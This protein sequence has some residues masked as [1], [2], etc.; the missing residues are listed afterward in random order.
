MHPQPTQHLP[1]TG[2]DS[3]VQRATELELGMIRTTLSRLPASHLRTLPPIV[4]ADTIAHGSHHR[5][6]AF[7]PQFAID[8][9]ARRA[10]GVMADL[11]AT[12]WQNR[13]RLELT[14]EALARPQ[15]QRDGVIYTLLHETGHAVD[16]QFHIARGLT[17][18]S[19]GTIAYEGSHTSETDPRGPVMERFGDA[20]M[21]YWAG[22]L[23]GKD[24]TAFETLQTAMQAVDPTAYTPPPPAPRDRTG[25][26]HTPG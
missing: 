11:Q 1:F 8:Q 24:Q 18:D 7:M 12:G 22:R 15:Y 26:G 20:Y 9:Y 3:S 4:V 21:Y 2:V 17:P 23:P 5:G 16:A 13:P 14:H 6:G 25:S 10:P 19:L